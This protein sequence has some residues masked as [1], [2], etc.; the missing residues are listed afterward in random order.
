MRVLAYAGLCNRSSDHLFGIRGLFSAVSVL[1]EMLPET[2]C[3]CCAE[4]GSLDRFPSHA[5]GLFCFTAA[6][7][8]KCDP[9]HAV[10]IFRSAG[11]AAG[12]FRSLKVRFSNQQDTM[13]QTGCF[14]LCDDSG[15]SSLFAGRSG[16]S[17]MNIANSDFIVQ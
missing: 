9:G 6:S 11:T 8:C 10:N 4:C 12:C 16:S 14:R 15:H 7:I 2:S 13:D 3:L 1:P 5:D 17:E